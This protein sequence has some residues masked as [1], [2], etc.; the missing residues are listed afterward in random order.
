MRFKYLAKDPAGNFKKGIVEASSKTS[1]IEV[2]S[3]H[4]LTA[5]TLEEKK[6]TPLLSSILKIWEGTKTRDFVIFSRQLA[7]MIDAKVP[8]LSALNSIAD[9]TENRFLALKI[10]SI[11]ADVDSGMSFSEAIAKHPDTF[12][13][14]YINMVK[15]GEASGTLQQN[16]N[17]LADNIEANYELTAKLRG[18]LYYP[19]FILFAM[20]AVGF[21]VMTFV[22][23]KLLVI[24]KESNVELPLT[25]KVL[26]AT[27]GFLA[28]YW[29]IVLIIFFVAVGAFIYYIKTDQGKA[30]FD[31]LVFK[32]PVVN[33]LVN[34]VYVTRFTENFSTLLQS[35]LPI[36]T[37]LLITSEIVGNERYRDAILDAVQ[38]VKKGG[39]VSDALRKHGVVPLVVVQMIKIG[40]ATGK[41]DYAL[42]KITE[43]YIKETDRVVKNFSSLIEPILM[44][45]LAIGVGILVSAVI[46]PIY[47]VA[48]SVQ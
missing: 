2:L 15:A 17:N 36:T 10:K 43:F 32:I 1:A 33:K 13:K 14:F 31:Y 39:T 25:T 11:I 45:F 48:T 26:I 12:S 40:E 37:A 6:E 29:W 27:S 38:E 16:L 21:I 5:V 35:G 24:L 41:I 9:Q 34:N 20:L 19:G 7:V 8:L 44:V 4:N 46:L 18:A 23:P 47:Q 22:M 28:S 42:K 3:R 30:E